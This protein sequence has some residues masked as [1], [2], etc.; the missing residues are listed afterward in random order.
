MVAVRA[1]A[2]LPTNSSTCCRRSLMAATTPAIAAKTDD[3][4]LT[5]TD[6]ETRVTHVRACVRSNVN[7]PVGYKNRT[8]PIR[9]PPVGH[10]TP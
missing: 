9:L 6:L 2:R 7:R 4:K 8:W 5:A 1:F 3:G 10:G